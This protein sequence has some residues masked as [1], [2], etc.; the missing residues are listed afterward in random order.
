MVGEN[1]LLAG[2][3]ALSVVDAL[4]RAPEGLSFSKLE[5]EIGVSAASL[6][7]LLKMLLNE[8]WIETEQRGRYVVGARTMTLARHLSGHWSEHEIIE[9]VVKDLAIATGHSA[10]FARFANDSFVLTTKTEMPSSFHFIELYFK[11]YELHDNGMA[12]TLLAYQEPDIAR[13]LLEEQIG[14]GDIEGFV[15]LLRTI[16]RDGHHISRE[17]AVTRIAVPVHQ[18]VGHTVKGVVAIAAINMNP[19]ET[20]SCLNSVRI[21]A[22]EAERRLNNRAD[23]SLRLAGQNLP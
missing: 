13:Y 17:G 11:H 14:D 15:A 8:G 23:L 21:A 16:R 20:D 19:D 12:L 2:R 18:G 4:S 5:I 3:R 10:C 9:P 7:R 1:Q 22:E 6:S